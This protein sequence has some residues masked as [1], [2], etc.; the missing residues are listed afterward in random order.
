MGKLSIGA[1]STLRL[2]F[3]DD[4]GTPIDAIEINGTRVGATGDD[5]FVT[6]VTVRARENLNPFRVTDVSP[7]QA[8]VEFRSG[9]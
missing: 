9:S 1:G 5:W 6:D 2:R 4:D 8:V 3:E 7:K